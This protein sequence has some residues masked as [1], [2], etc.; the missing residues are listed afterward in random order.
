MHIRQSTLSRS[1]RQLE[2]SIGATL[3]ERS[4]GGVRPTLAGRRIIR[5]AR[6]ILEELDALVLTSGHSGAIERLAIGFCTSLSAGNLR[7][8]ILEFKQ[9]FPRIEITTTERSE[10]RLATF[11]RNGTL[12]ILVIPGDISIHDGKS[13]ALW[14]EQLFVTLPKDHFLT[15]RDVVYWTDLRNETLLLSQYD[16]GREIV[17]II[18]AKLVS[19]AD[20]PKIERHGVSRG[21][22]KALVS[23]R[24]GISLVLESDLGAD[25][26]SLSC[27]ELRDGAG[28]T[29]LGFSAVWR[30][31]NENPALHSLLTLLAER[32]PSPEACG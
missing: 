13:L 31:D 27:R 26:S 25:V 18:T 24:M 7:L 10:A 1:V 30:A 9:R 20:R 16:H 28:P 3:F 11:L 29:Q 17:D 4:S 32:Y 19:P 14:S 22:I 8:T 2:T 12:D 5:T 6:T 15:E 23:M 21:A